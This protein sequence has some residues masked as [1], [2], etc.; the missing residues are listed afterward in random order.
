MQLSSYDPFPTEVPV[1]IEDNLF[2]YPFM[3]SPIFLTKSEDIEAATYAMEKNSLILLT[4]TK[5]GKEGSRE[6]NDIHK[7]G[8][9]GSIMRKVNLPDGRVKILFQGMARGEFVGKLE[10]VE[11]D[12]VSF[13]QSLVQLLENKKFDLLKVSA[14]IGV[15]NE[16]LKL[17]AKI[18]N[19]IPADLL[20]T[21][22]ET[23]DPYRIVDLVSS[24]LKLSK[25]D[26][27]TLY[28]NDDIEQRLLKIIDIIVSEME[29]A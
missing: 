24:L 9:I 18:N 2:L 8:V 11:V 4:T 28:A 22:S 3:I 23:D 25:T 29:S 16:K 1:I 7:I 13:E 20:K 17:F 19:S 10:R 6:E 27:Y 15:L 14:L 26:A 5:E 21:I 12:D